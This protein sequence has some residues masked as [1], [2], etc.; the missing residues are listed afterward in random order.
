MIKYAV[1]DK[2]TITE[3]IIPYLSTAKRG[4]VCKFCLCD[5]INAIFYKLK[6]GCQ[7]ENLPVKHLFEGD[8]PSYKT[9]FYHYRK[10]CKRA[11][12]QKMFACLMSKYK[13]LFDLSVS[14]IDGSHTPAVRGGEKVKY[15]GRKKRRTTNALY[16]VDRQGLPLAMSEPQEGNHADLYDIETRVEEMASQMQSAGINLDGLFNNADAGFDGKSFRDA[17]AKHGI[18]ANVCPNPRNGNSSEDYLFDPELYQERWVIER[19]NAW[20]DS[21]RSILT[22]F[23]TTVS[24]WKGWNYLAFAV[25]LLRRAHRANKFR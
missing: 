18:V 9:V 13:H 15:Q 8:V 4:L 24:S 10:W 22:R 11:E 1:L 25:L 23:D 7:W 21:F 2:D 17:L 19:T 14:H 3:E 12:W 5:V 16:F 6:T 20:M